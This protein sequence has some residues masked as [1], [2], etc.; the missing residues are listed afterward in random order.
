[1]GEG[2][3]VLAGSATFIGLSA[4][5]FYYVVGGTWFQLQSQT[6]AGAAVGWG[7]V[8]VILLLLTPV[9]LFLFYG[10]SVLAYAAGGGD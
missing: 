7:I 5:W 2:A 1:M 9:V 4:V 6:V 8:F 3:G 10:A